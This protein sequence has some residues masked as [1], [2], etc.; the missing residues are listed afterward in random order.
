MKKVSQ[1]S[2]I[3]KMIESEKSTNPLTFHNRKQI[4]MSAANVNLNERYR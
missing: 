3:I 2:V 1:K 4:M